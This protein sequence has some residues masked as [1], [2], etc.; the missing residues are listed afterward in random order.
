MKKKKR[1]PQVSSPIAGNKGGVVPTSEEDEQSKIFKALA[2]A[3]A[4]ASLDDAVS[5]FRQANGDPNK[6]TGILA[7]GS[8]YNVDD[9]STSLG[10]GS[11]EGIDQNRDAAELRR[12]SDRFSEG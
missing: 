7:M 3:F 6:A 4:L 12:S 1:R 10:S 2:E 11:R 5:V 8:G 9:P